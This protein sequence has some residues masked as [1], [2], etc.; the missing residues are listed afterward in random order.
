MIQVLNRLHTTYINT[1]HTN[2]ITTAI[3][4]RNDNI[5]KILLSLYFI[6]TLSMYTN[7]LQR[8]I[9]FAVNIY[10][11]FAYTAINMQLILRHIIYSVIGLL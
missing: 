8:I 1:I 2:N 11:N 10:Y 3:T 6:F 9:L 7:I 5:V 4:K